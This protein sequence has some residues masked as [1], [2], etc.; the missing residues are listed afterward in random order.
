M[1]EAKSSIRPEE[2]EE[3]SNMNNAEKP[4]RLFEY[5]G[6]N[7]LI[8]KGVTSGKTYHFRSSGD[9]ILIDHDD[10]FA[11]MAERDLRIVKTRLNV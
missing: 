1:N 2:T 11:L 9:K 3:T 8:I 7:S 4:D 10:S 5:T 6:N